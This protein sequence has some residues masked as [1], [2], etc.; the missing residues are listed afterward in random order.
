M[1]QVLPSV[2]DASSVTVQAT[3]RK[4]TTSS[5]YMSAN[6]N[7]QRSVA[8]VQHEVPRL[9]ILLHECSPAGVELIN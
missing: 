1:Q 9:C 2:E 5:Q 7:D 8:Y 3:Q 6:L 4:V